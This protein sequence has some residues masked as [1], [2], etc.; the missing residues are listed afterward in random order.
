[1]LKNYLKIAARNLRINRTYT[2]LN[3]TGLA[4][5]ISGSI[6]IFIFLQYHLSFDRHQSNHDRLYR[7]VLDLHLDEGLEYESGSSIPLGPALAR[8]FP[9]IEKAGLIGKIP[10]AT[11]SAEKNNKTKRFLEK[12]NTVYADQNYLEMFDFD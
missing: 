3:V 10:D 4:L 11:F 6:L 1:M 5:G 9:Q 12:A 7:V 8:D 2:L